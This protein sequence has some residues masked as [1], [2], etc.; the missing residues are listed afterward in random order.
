MKLSALADRPSLEFVFKCYIQSYIPPVGPKHSYAEEEG[1]KPAFQALKDSVSPLAL[2][3][4]R[5]FVLRSD[6][7]IALGIN[8]IS[9]DYD[10]QEL[11]GTLHSNCFDSLGRLSLWE[12]EDNHENK[13]WYAGF[14][15]QRAHYLEVFLSCGRFSRVGRT[16]ESIEPLSTEQVLIL[17]AFLSSKFI[18]AYGKQEVIF[19]DTLPGKQDEQDSALFF[20]DIAFPASKEM[21]IYNE[22]LLKEIGQLAINQLNLTTVEHYLSSNIPLIKPKYFYDN[23]KSINPAFENI[24]M[25]TKPLKL[26]EKRIW[27]LRG[28][29]LLVTGVKNAYEREYGYEG[30]KQVFNPALYQFINWEDRYGHPSLALPELDYDGSVFYAGYLCQKKDFLQVYLVS[31]RFDRKD[32]NGLQTEILE[33]Y[34]A[35]QLQVA[36]GQQ[37]VVFEFGDPDNPKFHQTFFSHGTFPKENP[38]RI[39][40]R[41][42]I[43]CLLFKVTNDERERPEKLEI[44]Y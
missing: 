6:F 42:D 10:C 29:F 28:D 30:L 4:K 2:N 39:Y 27:L 25:I 38:R 37:A 44:R 1:I 23:E 5:T 41:S 22:H 12:G 40:S 3:D 31:G 15:C 16:V 36:Y 11:Q 24:Q 43:M 34:I 13:V 33:A 32:L 26:N 8:N 9:R 7:V 21:R 19:Y 20:R 18:H 17:E 35:L 14:I